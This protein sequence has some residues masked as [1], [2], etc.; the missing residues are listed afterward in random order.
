MRSLLVLPILATS[1][2]AQQ[3]Q[4]RTLSKPT[5]EYSEPF[6][7]VIAAYELKDG[8]LVTADPRDKT[9]LAVDIRAGKTTPIGREGAGPQEWG[10]IRSISGWLGD[11]LVA[12]D[13]LNSRYLIIDPGAK[14]IRTF[15]TVTGDA[16]FGT[17]GQPPARGGE[18]GRG[19]AAGSAGGG[20]GGRGGDAARSGGAGDG[21]VTFGG[22]GSVPRLS[23]GGGMRGSDARGRIYS[24]DLALK[25]S[26]AGIISAGDSAPIVRFDPA[27]SKRDTIAYVNLA[28]NSAGGAARGDGRGQT[29]EL[30]MGSPNPFPAA[31]DWTV[32]RDGTV[33][34]VRVSDYHVEVIPPSGRRAAGRPVAFTPV[35]VTEADKQQWR[36]ARKNNVPI[37]R[38]FGD[39]GGRAQT[40]TQLPPAQE[41]DSWPETKPPFLTNAAFA[42][43][44]GD[45]WVVRARSASDKIP[46][47]DVFSAQGQQV[48]RVV[49]PERTRLVALGAKGVYLVRV[50]DDDLQYLQHH[51]LQWTGCTPE[52]RENCAR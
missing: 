1:A 42:A 36:D 16:P 21:R 24:Q 44:N 9:L 48:G 27:T 51:A 30:R 29:V 15:S 32:F 17:G 37:L 31:D 7:Q 11:S 35:R 43:P 39:G 23:G 50:D 25:I 40:N 28:K 18:G 38:S 14:P 4:T 13:G 47:A 26:D 52:L 5:A 41:P 33:A 6:S 3:V 22:G 8:R 46:T 49:F 12:Y 34:I 2:A 20:A 45:V 19:A 10:S